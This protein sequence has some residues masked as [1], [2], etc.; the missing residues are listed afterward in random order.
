[1]LFIGFGNISFFSPSGRLLKQL[2]MGS[3]IKE[4]CFFGD[5]EFLLHQPRF[6]TCRTVDACTIL[7]LTREDFET[8]LDQFPADV[9]RVFYYCCNPLYLL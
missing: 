3:N 6:N 4:G 8:V 2:K 7:E 5:V 9:Q 1:M